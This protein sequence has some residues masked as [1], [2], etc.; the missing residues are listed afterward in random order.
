MM[1]AILMAIALQTAAQTYRPLLTFSAYPELRRVTTRVDVGL[2]AGGRGTK[3]YWFRK[4]VQPDGGEIAETLW[5]VTLSCPGG[6]SV[7][8]ELAALEGPRPHVY[9]LDGRDDIVM[10]ADG[11]TYRLDAQSA[12]PFD[13]GRIT[14]RTN[15]GT[16][17]AR[18]VEAALSSL[19]GCW[20]QEPPKRVS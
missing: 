2:L 3:D 15:R 13:N 16:P 11:V 20:K 10:M 8:E 9:G 12:P 19:A 17:L 4:T 14:L 1:A 18:W 7:L 5:A 6:R